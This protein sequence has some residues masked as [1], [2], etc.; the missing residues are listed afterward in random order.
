MKWYFAS[1]VK[2][3]Q[4][5]LEVSRFLE[6]IGETVVSDWI[7]K[8]SLKPY[9]DHLSEVRDFSEEVLRSILATDIFVLVSDP[10]GTDMFVELGICLAN[11]TLTSKVRIYIVGEHSKRSI[12]QLHPSITHV[13][14]LK[15]VFDIEKI[16]SIKFAFPHFTV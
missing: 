8:G 7:Y 1:R 5:I 12:M 16:N 4:K 15:E 11:K 3:Q 6:T 10:D 13:K 14:D 2:H 9:I